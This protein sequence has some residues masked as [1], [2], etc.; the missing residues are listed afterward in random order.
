MSSS[1]RA[2]SRRFRK[3]MGNILVVLLGIIALFLLVG[4]FLPRNYRV[5]RSVVINARPEAI[6]PDLA[7]LRRWPEWTV[8][9]QQMDPS[10]KFVF[11]SPETGVGAAYRWT[12]EKMGSGSLKLTT[13]NP[14]NGVV[15]DL[16]FEGGMIRAEG[17]IRFGAAAGGSGVEVTWINEGDL[18]KNPVNRYFGLTMDSMLGEQMAKGLSNLKARA[19]GGAAAK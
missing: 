18:G 12:G 5:E 3:I 1:R 6:Y 7:D 13:A 4:L 15:Y 19:E 14:T 2:R 17:T 9:N 8:W 10:A 11:D 16:D